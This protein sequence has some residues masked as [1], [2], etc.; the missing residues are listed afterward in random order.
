MVQDRGD[1]LHGSKKKYF[2]AMICE[3]N[4]TGDSSVTAPAIDMAE[5][6]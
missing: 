2:I 4:R 6:A 3:G 1:R 5:I